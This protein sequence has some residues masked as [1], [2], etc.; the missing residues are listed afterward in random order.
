M[1][2]SLGAGHRAAVFGPTIYLFTFDRHVACQFFL[3][4][5]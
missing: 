4:F 1:S 3:P 2:W 5:Q